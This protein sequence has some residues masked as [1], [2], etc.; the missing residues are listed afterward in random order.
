MSSPAV[1]KKRKRR[2][3][4][5]AVEEKAVG[6]KKSKKVVNPAVAEAEEDEEVQ[7]KVAKIVD[8]NEDERPAASDDEDEEAGAELPSAVGLPA[9]SASLVAPPADSE[10]FEELRLSERSMKAIN[11][12]GFT[13]MTAIQRAVSLTM[14]A[15]RFSLNA[16]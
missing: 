6:K 5:A 13:K 10:S 12:M 3:A 1:E 15:I 2:A 8:A 9:A 14:E 7:E 4:E 11:K 16:Y